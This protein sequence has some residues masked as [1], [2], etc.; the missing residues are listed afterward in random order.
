MTNKVVHFALATS[1]IDIFI[2]HLETLNMDY[3]DWLNTPNKDYIRK[4]NIKHRLTSK[5]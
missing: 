5:G 2:A 1:Q 3:S 4:D